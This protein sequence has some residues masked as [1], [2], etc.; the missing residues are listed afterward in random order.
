M[1]WALPPTAGIGA[2]LEHAKALGIRAV[3]QNDGEVFEFGGMQA[4]VFS[5]P[6]TWITSSQPRNHDSLVLRFRYRDSSAL[7]EG[8][9]E[10]VVEQRLVASH[11]LHADLLK[12]GH[13]GSN[14]SSTLE[15]LNAVHP[16]WA[17]IS[18]GARNTFGHP[19][20]ETLERLEGLGTATHRTDRNGAVTFCLDG[21]T[22][23]PQLASLR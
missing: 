17:I 18:V 14:T 13:H 5:P 15:L 20:M 6:A 9:A 2:V 10:R 1:D 11:D 3:R 4:E 8:D 23:N 19:R 21:H 7:L 16:R 12:V 22:V